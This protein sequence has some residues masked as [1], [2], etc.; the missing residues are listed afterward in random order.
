MDFILLT[1]CGV[2]I[3]ELITGIVLLLAMLDDGIVYGWILQVID[4]VISVGRA[5]SSSLFDRWQ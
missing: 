3:A 2:L 1:M 5:C 4:E